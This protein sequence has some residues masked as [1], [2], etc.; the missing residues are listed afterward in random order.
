MKLRMYPENSI[1][2]AP[3]SGYTDLPY[4]RSARRYGCR[5]CFTEMIDA[6]S[7]A[8]GNDK[9]LRYMER[10]ADEEWLGVQLVGSNPE[11]IKR[12]VEVLNEREFDVLDFNL[13]CPVPKVAK[14]EAGAKLGKNIK[15][16]VEIFSI[17]AEKSRFPVTAKIRI[18]DETDPEPTLELVSGLAQAGA[19]A[20]TIHGRIMKSFYSGPVFADII[21]AASSSLPVQVIA[22]GGI[23]NW[24]NR[25]ELQKKSD[26]DC[27][28]LARG[29]MGNPWIFRELCDQKEYQPPT[30]AELAGELERH[31]LEL[32]NYLGAELAMKAGRK[33]ILDYLKSRGFTGSVKAEVS[34]LKTALDF[35]NFMKVVRRGPSERYRIWLN[36]NPD[37]DRRLRF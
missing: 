20:V 13:G 19:R 24:R 29:A 4:R 14:K 18:L 21:R 37:A 26:C 12:A 34:S 33:I 9:T 8:F 23:T 27:V 15:R 25:N 28:M 22:N 35:E 6:G 30:P 7:L 2:L 11:F 36:S 31:M 32:I 10:G 5:F 16:A 17:I 3:L 1:L